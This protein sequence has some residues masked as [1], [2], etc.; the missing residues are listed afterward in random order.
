[1]GDR[2]AARWGRAL[3]EH[4]AALRAFLDTAG[5]LDDSRWAEP[6]APGKWSRGQVVQHMVLTYEALLRELRSAEAM[7]L[8]FSPFKRALLRWVLLPHILFHRSFPLRAIAPR[9]LRPPEEVP[10]RAGTL[11]RL[12]EVGES[13][14][15]EAEE[16]WRR[17]GGRLTHPYFGSVPLLTGLRF[18]AVHT[19]HH[20]RQISA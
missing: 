12:A 15:R 1:M 18:L 4:R 20:R 11:A 10:E 19:E 8:R 6:F 16:V 13:F 14:E 5:G 7:R 3:G 2:A 9:E 17:G